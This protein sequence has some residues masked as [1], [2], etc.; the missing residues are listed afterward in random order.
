MASIARCRLIRQI[1]LNS[2]T[3]E[4]I[5][6]AQGSATPALSKGLT[7][8]YNWVIR[9]LGVSFK[10]QNHN[11]LMPRP[12]KCFYERIYGVSETSGNAIA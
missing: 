11:A 10:G 1:P 12:G 5:F 2:G 7:E 4:V 6:Q 9:P 3:G 8:D